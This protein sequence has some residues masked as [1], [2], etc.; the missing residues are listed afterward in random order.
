MPFDDRKKRWRSTRESIVPK[1]AGH[2]V[3]PQKHAFDP[4]PLK[5]R[6]AKSRHRRLD[7]IRSESAAT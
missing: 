6:I 1:Q 3:N 2:I 7:G 5:W 4:P